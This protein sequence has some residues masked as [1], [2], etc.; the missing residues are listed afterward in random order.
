MAL[1]YGLG[2]LAVLLA[3]VSALCSPVAALFAGLAASGY[4]L[5]GLLRERR[6]LAALPG[7]GV[8]VAAL[9]PVGLIAI[10]FPE[11]GVE[12]FGWSTMLPVLALAAAAFATAPRESVRLRAGVAIYGLAVIGSFLVP[13]PVGSNVARL[14][15][16]LA[17]PLATLLWWDGRRR[18]L[19]ILI[20][21]LLYLGWEAPVRD[22]TSAS[23]DQSTSTQYYA[24][25]VQFLRHQHGPPFR[26]EIPFTQFHWEAYVVATHFP[27]ARGWER[28]LDVKDNPIFYGG[29][30]TAASYERWLDAN[31]VRFVAAPDA[32]LDYSAQAEMALIDHGLPYLHLVMRSPHWRVYAVAHATP[33]VD[34]PA[35]LTALGPDS[36]TIHADRAGVSRT[37][38]LHPVL[39]ALGRRGLRRPGRSIHAREPSGGGHGE[40]DHQLFGEPDR[41]RQ[42]TLQLICASL[43]R[44]FLTRTRH[45]PR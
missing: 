14:G 21:P 35:T 22:L 28:Q 2:W 12:P 39:D 10:A 17:A 40:A 30:L 4:A 42:R 36:L 41:R 5:G 24:P 3:L 11:G 25:L 26:I 19:A 29:Y 37:R 33:I 18:L 32:Q 45:E 23:N 16:F 43:R 38:S 27:L 9:L 15:A 13:S 44:E 8:I 31:A 7:V 6:L 20:L 1:D 34:G